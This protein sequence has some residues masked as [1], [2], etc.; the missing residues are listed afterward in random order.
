MKRVI[1]W[2]HGKCKRQVGARRGLSADVPG[3][4]RLVPG[5]G[6]LSGVQGDELAKTI[7][8][9]YKTE[10]IRKQ[11]PW[12]NI[13]AV[14]YATMKWVDWFNNRRLLEPIGDIP[15]AEFEML[16][17]VPKVHTSFPFR[18]S[19]IYLRAFA[20]LSLLLG[21]LREN[22]CKRL[23]LNGAIP[24]LLRPSRRAYRGLLASVL[25]TS[26]H[27]SQRRIEPYRYLNAV[28][29]KLPQARVVEDYEQLLPWNWSKTAG[30]AT[31]LKKTAA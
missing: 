11:G 28:F 20:S 9:L 2:L 8:G 12:H 25:R 3:D 22:K 30:T 5:R 4:G 1:R 26:I 29:T 10:V 24:L 15:P 13:D 7:N 19:I 31:I 23:G 18:T 16:Y 17:L 14:E 27:G 21:H 6:G